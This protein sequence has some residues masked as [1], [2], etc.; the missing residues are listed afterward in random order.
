MKPMGTVS[1]DSGYHND[2]H[3]CIAT[4]SHHQIGNAVSVLLQ[5]LKAVGR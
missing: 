4:P 3:C 2:T 5:N 1:T